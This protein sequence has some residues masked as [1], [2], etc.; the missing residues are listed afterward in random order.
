MA[1]TNGKLLR[2]NGTTW[3][4]SNTEDFFFKVFF[5]TPVAP[6]ETVVDVDYLSGE[7]KGVLLNDSDE[8]TTDIKLLMAVMVDDTVSMSWSERDETGYSLSTRL[9]LFFENILSRSQT[10]PVTDYASGYPVSYVDFWIYT[11][12]EIN[13]SL[14]FTNSI[15]DVETYS[16][17]LFKRGLFSTLLSSTPLM[18]NGLNRQSIVD[19]FFKDNADDSVRVGYLVEYLDAIGCLRLEEIYD[20]WTSINAAI[21]SDWADLYIIYPS[22]SGDQDNLRDTIYLYSDVSEYVVERW[23]KSFVPMAMVIADGDNSSSVSV[24]LAIQA[25][26]SA[27]DDQG[28]PIFTF[29]LGKSQSENYLRSMSSGTEGNHF[30]ISQESDWDDS[31][32]AILH[33]GDYSVF[34]AS[35]NKTYDFNDFTWI[36]EINATYTPSTPDGDGTSCTVEVRWSIDRL[37]FSSWNSVASGTPFILKKLVQVLEYRITLKDGWDG[38]DIIRPVLNT[39]AH[40]VVEPSVQYLF[41]PPQTIDGMMF[42]T[43]LS[44]AAFLPDTATATWGVS[45]GDSTDFADFAPVHIARKGALPNRQSGIVFTKEILFTKLPTQTDANGLVYFVY[46]DNTFSTLKT[47]ATSD[48]ILVYQRLNVG[49]EVLVPSSSYVINGELGTISF[50]RSQSGTTISVTIRTPPSLFSTRGEVTTTRDYKTYY[51]TNGRWSRDNSVIVLVNDKIVRGGFWVNPEEGTITFAKEREETD[52]VS[53]YIE[54]TDV[55][56]VGVEIKNYDPS[57]DGSGNPIPLDIRNFALFFNT[58]QNV[59]LQSEVENTSAPFITNQRM[60]PQEFDTSGALINPTIYQRLIVDYKFNSPDNAAESGTEIKWWRY[61]SGQSLVGQ[62]TQVYLGDTYILL[63]AYNNRITEKKSDVGTGVVFGAGDQIFVE[64]TPSDG[65]TVGRKVS[66]QVVTL[67]GDEPPFIVT[68]KK[69]VNINTSSPVISAPSDGVTWTVTAVSTSTSYFEAGTYFVGYSFINS[70]GETVASKLKSVVLTDFQSISIS[71]IALVSNATGINYYCSVKPN[72]YLTLSGSSSFSNSSTSVNGTSTKYLTELKVGDPVYSSTN[73]FLGKVGSISSDVLFTL[74]A[75]S[76]ANYS[77]ETRLIPVF[78]AQANTG[79]VTTVITEMAETVYVSA[80][81]L[82]R[83]PT[84]GLVSAPITDELT[85]VYSYRNPDNADNTPDETI[86]EWYLRDDPTVVKFT[87]KTIAANSVTKGQVY[88]FKATPYNG[89]RYGA[90]V[91]SS[92]VLMT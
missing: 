73:V 48:E 15:T 29:G 2:Y 11:N 22:S 9:P 76:V 12:T 86:I 28:A 69:P 39:L 30:Y 53:V 36:S 55:Y 80:P 44:A 24:D 58:L 45:R 4:A 87:G 59:K 18:L 46:T 8:L 25:A 52:S 47:W 89:V 6:V 26:N 43:L 83:D 92:T 85:A 61:R 50:Q 16:S 14:G 64:I 3:T 49:T 13:R 41:T 66:T 32:T 7:Y 31:E 72:S 17:A 54:F 38:T 79:S 74:I 90:P 42:E 60:L 33:G 71:S 37:N 81:N 63:T 78:L 57:V 20:Y 75:N 82:S 21:R 62:T 1:Y 84:T 35:V 5:N 27:W 65:Y 88:I 10:T 34:T 19:A 67:D 56:R 51:L 68:L 77:G 40:T 23:A 91:W 70:N